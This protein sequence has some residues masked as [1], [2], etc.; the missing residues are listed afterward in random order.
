MIHMAA[1][2]ICSILVRRLLCNSCVVFCLLFLD[3]LL[4]IFTHLLR[5]L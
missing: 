5:C 4:A 1:K 2:I 3:F